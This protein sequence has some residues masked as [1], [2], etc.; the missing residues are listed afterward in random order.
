MTIELSDALPQ[1]P[2]YKNLTF[3]RGFPRKF[4][5]VTYGDSKSNKMGGMN[6]TD[7]SLR[8]A[9]LMY[10]IHYEITGADVCGVSGM[11]VKTEAGHLANDTVMA[12]M[13]ARFAAGRNTMIFKGFTNDSGKSVAEDMAA[14]RK[15]HEKARAAGCQLIIIMGLN[16]YDPNDTVA[17]RKYESIDQALR[18]YEHLNDDA[19]YVPTTLA[20]TNLASNDR[21]SITAPYPVLSDGVHENNR[22]AFI[23]GQVLA[24]EF[25]RRGVPRRT[26]RTLSAAD[27]NYG[28]NIGT[29]QQSPAGNFL[30]PLGTFTLIGNTTGMQVTNAG[31]GTLPDPAQWVGLNTANTWCKLT[32]QLTGS[33]SL[34]IVNDACDFLNEEGFRTDVVRP[35]L[36]LS[37][38]T[39]AGGMSLSIDL[40]RNSYQAVSPSAALPGGFYS[41]G[42][43]AWAAKN[44]AG[45]AQVK[46]GPS[47]GGAG[48]APTIPVP[49]FSALIQE[50]SAAPV[51]VAGNGSFGAYEGHIS[52]TWDF[53]PNQVLDGS[54]IQ[55]IAAANRQ[56]FAVQPAAA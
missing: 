12:P 20:L 36:V 28:P 29:A 41:E 2:S 24:R 45:L 25:Q 6:A 16:P 31:T 10:P 17:A 55:L 38:T 15:I 44:L 19:W 22:G 34:A 48:A 49:T 32:G 5:F 21:T 43:F 42:E 13:L 27:A 18:D 11:A 37:G 7:S 3:R 39:G 33:V 40:Y 51:W 56:I 53:A 54:S 35:R 52:T 30:G 1:V 47:M 26:I 9:M 23:E 46:G 4:K 50:F 14:F 8:F